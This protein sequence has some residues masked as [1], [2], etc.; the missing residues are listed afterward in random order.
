MAILE[1]PDRFLEKT[2]PE[3]NLAGID[4][5]KKKDIS[6]FKVYSA[7]DESVL[8][9]PNRFEKMTSI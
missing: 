4:L 1:L 7:K 9:L 8:E 6:L 5:D 2:K 3:L